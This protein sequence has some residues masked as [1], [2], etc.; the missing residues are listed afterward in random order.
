VSEMIVTVQ[1]AGTTG[2]RQKDVWR[3]KSSS[4]S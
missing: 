3:D 2:Y 1:C 4:M